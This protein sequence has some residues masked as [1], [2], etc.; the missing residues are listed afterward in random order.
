MARRRRQDKTD[1]PMRLF[2]IKRF[3]AI[4]AVVV[5]AELAILSLERDLLLPIIT[6]L[7]SGSRAPDGVL[8]SFLR[9]LLLIAPIV[10]PVAA[11]A[12][13]FA[14]QTERRIAAE[15]E[16]RN[17]ERARYFQRRNLMI[18]DM[19][20]DL[21]TPV[22]SISGLAQAL[23]DGMVPDEATRRRYLHSITAKSEKMADLVNILF[24]Y[25]Q[26]DSEGYR[27]DRKCIDL[28][29]L[30]LREAASA[31]TDVEDG[32]MEL[33][34][35]VP[36][37]PLA[38][39]ADERQLGRVV[40]NLI[41]NAV[42]HND[43]GTV[44]TLAL[45]RRAGVAD[46]VVADTGEPIMRDVGELFEPFARGD[47]ARSG[48]GSGLGLSIAKTIVDMHGYQIH[49]VQPYGTYTK[50]FVVTCTVEV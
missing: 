14:N 44:I 20:H 41:A 28:P 34:V 15:Q 16:A 42:R 37:A 32:G 21:R 24:D 43:A 8:Q 38:V 26:L 1:E 3:V 31:Y 18:S 10:V 39:Y 45:G 29:Q 40:A 36:E 25:V 7:G 46:V 4:S 9:S 17:A 12:I 35:E 22:M 23:A 27:L 47:A 48:G 30:L 49:L 50:A 33:R 19:A 2:I 6:T 13:V 11:G 5:L